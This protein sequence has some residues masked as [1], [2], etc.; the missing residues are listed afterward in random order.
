MRVRIDATGGQEEIM[1]A[2]GSG[3]QRAADVAKEVLGQIADSIVALGKA[4]APVEPGDGG[5][6][7]DSIRKLR[8]VSTKTVVSQAIVV[9]GAPLSGFLEE[10][11]HAYN[12]YA[13]L[14]EYDVGKDAP[15]E[16]TTGEAHFLE[17]PTFA[18][19]PTI[20]DRVISA[21]DEANILG[22]A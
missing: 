9:G 15:F 19:A 8:A 12:I 6:M 7:R 11:H 10:T 14:Q 21:F 22:G 13:V 5:Q 18:L 20:P 2:L 17:T 1:E 16:H 3:G 4:N